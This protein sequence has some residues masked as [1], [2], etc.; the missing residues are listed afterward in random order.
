MPP[1][2]TISGVFGLLLLTACSHS[3]TE[4]GSSDG[5]GGSNAVQI[6]GNERL[7]WDQRASDERDLLSL[8]F[9]LH[10]DNQRQQ[11]LD[12]ACGRFSPGQTVACSAQLPT[13][14]AGLHTLALS[15]IDPFGFE[16]SPSAAIRVRVVPQ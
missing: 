7:G 2:S 11:L 3:P 6:R 16:S 1:P 15:T 4:P 13:L 9:F 10:T 8:R 14:S 12:V 5:P